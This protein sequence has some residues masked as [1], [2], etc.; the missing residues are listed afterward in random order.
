MI[1]R[2]TR[3][4][5][6]GSERT[7]ALVATFVYAIV[8]AFLAAHHEPWFDELQAWRIAIDSAGIADLSR[9][10][11]YE[12]HPILWYL[13]LQAVG[14]VS[15]SWESAVIAHVLIATSLA[16]LIL[17]YAPF[18]RL[19]RCLVVSGYFFVYEYAAIVRGYGL[20][21][22]LGFAACAAWCAPKRRV[23][24]AAIALALL[25]NTSA[26]GL[27]LAI[28]LTAGFA[29]DAITSA[30]RSRPTSGMRWGPLVL[31]LTPVTVAAMIATQ[32][33]QPPKDARYQGSGIVDQTDRLWRIGHVATFPARVFVPLAHEP[34]G[35]STR[36]GSWRFEPA[37][38]IEKAGADVA[39]LLVVVIATMI[40]VR[41]RIGL[42]V[43]LAS[44]S[45][46]LIFFAVFH[47]GSIRHHGYI[48]V[49]FLLAAWL[50][51]TGPPDNWPRA[52]SRMAERCASLRSPLL[53]VMLLPM[54][55]AAA[56]AADA[57]V[58]YEFFSARA[59]ATRIE[60][61]RLSGV[62]IVGVAHL[63][64][65]AVAAL[66]DE[67]VYFPRESRRSTWTDF[68]AYRHSAPLAEL[69]DS[70]VSEL[71]RT[72]CQVVLLSSD[73]E[74]LSRWVQGLSRE[75]P[76]TSSDPMVGP[77]MRLWLAS[78]VALGC[79]PSNAP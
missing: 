60:E 10:L 31:A 1:E 72:N 70:V 35:R 78:A 23:T 68:G 37:T 59:I 50:S 64:P 24:L 75:L 22:L 29:F 4:E 57:E 28:A 44:L 27:V 32:Q 36:W 77:R 51:G 58:R 17:R 30:L 11:R 14:T 45:G 8:V 20:G 74:P 2:S 53:T 18:S 62:P 46:L 15:R 42:F 3:F 79:R 52:F 19:Q 26:V 13:V 34:A 16:W 56:R 65:Q 76:T 5:S 66:L 43:W 69:A 47:L 12:G 9:N 67:P 38:R 40:C 6:A 63:S 33:M 7:F 61:E 73:Q 49:A 71:L 54:V 48:A 21:A 41:R 39:A 25:A 55:L